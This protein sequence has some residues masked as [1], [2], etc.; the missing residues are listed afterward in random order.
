MAGPNLSPPDPQSGLLAPRTQPTTS[1]HFI[2]QLGYFY[3]AAL[4][5]PCSEAD[6]PSPLRKYVGPSGKPPTFTAQQTTKAAR[7]ETALRKAIYKAWVAKEGL[8][9]TGPSPRPSDSMDDE[10][11]TL[12][13]AMRRL[14][15][16]LLA[17]PFL[18][19]FIRC[20]GVTD[21]VYTL[22]QASNGCT[23]PLANLKKLL[24]GSRGRFGRLVRRSTQTVLRCRI[25]CSA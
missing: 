8:T 1:R 23:H 15:V 22:R 4:V 9:D 10:K 17:L 3:K 19:L 20:N 16:C 6:E 18:P 2:Y 25:F 13:T 7:R 11:T 24:V 5:F 14:S 12:S 21:H